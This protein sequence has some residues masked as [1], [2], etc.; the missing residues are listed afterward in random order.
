MSEIVSNGVPEVECLGC[1]RKVACL[2][3]SDG[4]V[5][6]PVTWLYNQPKWPTLGWCP[7]CQHAARATCSKSGDKHDG[8]RAGQGCVG[9]DAHDGKAVHPGMT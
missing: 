7:Q 5:Y 2:R 4:T 6:R 9:C 8:D 3:V 1:E